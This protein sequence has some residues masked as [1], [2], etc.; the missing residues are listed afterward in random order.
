M[1]DILSQCALQVFEIWLK[2]LK[3][4]SSYRADKIFVTDRQMDGR[5]DGRKG[6]NIISPDPSTG[7][8]DDCKVS[9]VSYDR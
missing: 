3:R 2:F 5:T 4:F 1:H 7:R 8:H 9:L 6:E